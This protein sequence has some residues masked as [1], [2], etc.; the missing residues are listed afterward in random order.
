MPITAMM[1]FDGTNYWQWKKTLMMLLVVQKIKE[2]I[3]MDPLDTPITESFE[4]VKKQYEDWQ[5]DSRCCMIIMK[6]YMD[7]TV[8]ASL[9]NIDTVKQVF[10]KVSKKFANVKINKKY[11]YMTLLNNTKYDG[12]KSMRDY[13]LL[14]TS[15][16]NKL[17]D[18]QMVMGDKY[19]SFMILQSL[20]VQYD[21]LRSSLNTKSEGGQLM[22]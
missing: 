4:E 20:L 9:P 14:L 18:L 5:Y 12:V 10:E 22:N 3:E 7:D 13:I 16:F 8:Y 17:K 1:K 15:Y 11:H 6:S 19:L 21:T 2:A